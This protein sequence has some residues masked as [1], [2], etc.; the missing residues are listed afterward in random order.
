MKPSG[1]DELAQGT[2]LKGDTFS[3]AKTTAKLTYG[4]KICYFHISHPNSCVF[5]HYKKHPSTTGQSDSSCHL[6]FTV[7][8]QSA[9][10]LDRQPRTQTIAS[11]V[12]T[13]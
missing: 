3:V 2:R 10:W 13:T 6:Q 9:S 1:A 7:D 12:H 11:C 8:H 5:M 4:C